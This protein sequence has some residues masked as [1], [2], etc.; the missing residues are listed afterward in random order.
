MKL[1]A[2]QPDFD[3]CGIAPAIHTASFGDWKSL[4]KDRGLYSIWQ[5][6]VCIYVGQGG[7][8]TGIKHR[9]H[10]HHNKAYA[11]EQSGTSH[12]KGWV[13]NR[14][15]DTWQ[16]ETWHIEYVLVDS[17]VHRT[18][19]EGTM[20]LVFDPLCNDESYEDRVSKSSG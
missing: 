18:Y 6:D 1:L 10:H 7:G 19:L 16:P 4:P 9:F 12:G 15:T 20:I 8:N 2:L 3:R 5:G 11:I 14:Q 13:E 17:A